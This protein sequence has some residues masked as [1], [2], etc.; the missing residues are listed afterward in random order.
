MRPAGLRV[1]HHLAIAVI[2][3]QEHAAACLA[4]GRLD[5]AD[6]AI[7]RFHGF[8]CR[9]QAAGMADH[10][11]VGEIADDQIVFAALD[12][13]DQLFGQLRRGHFRLQVI[14]PDFR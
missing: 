2:G 7:D 10:I 5:L 6:S 9:F 8:D 3:C 11:G 12:G 14:G 13:A 4:Q 1:L